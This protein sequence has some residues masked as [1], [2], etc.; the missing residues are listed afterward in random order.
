MF[1]K[2]IKTN[3]DG[4][5]SIIAVPVSPNNISG[6][7]K[8]PQMAAILNEARSD[9]YSKIDEEVLTVLLK[10]GTTILVVDSFTR[11]SKLANVNIL[12]G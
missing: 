9:G 7:E 6:V 10:N 12:H 8:T 5:Y 2:Q 1:L 3:D 4:T 11:L